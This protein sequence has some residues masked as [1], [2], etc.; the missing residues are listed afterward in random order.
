VSWADSGEEI[1]TR[2]RASS[3]I[4]F[5][6]F[7]GRVVGE[8]AFVAAVLRRLGVKA[9]SL[10]PRLRLALLLTL[11]LR[12]FV[13]TAHLRGVRP[14]AQVMNFDF[15]DDLAA[16]ALAQ[17]PLQA[18]HHERFRVLMISRSCAS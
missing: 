7:T 1:R 3:F 5:N 4:I 13:E 14:L 9:F 15:D 10:L 16:L 11:A 17:C 2:A 18:E 12:R 6:K 8:L